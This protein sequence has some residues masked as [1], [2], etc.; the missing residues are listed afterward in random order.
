M[1]KIVCE[2]LLPRRSGALSKSKSE[3][4]YRRPKLSAFYWIL[5]LG[6]ITEVMDYWILSLFAY[7]MRNSWLP[8]TLRILWNWTIAIFHH[9]PASKF[10]P[11]MGCHYKVEAGVSGRTFECLGF[12]Q[13]VSRPIHYELEGVHIRTLTPAQNASEVGALD[14]D[15]GSGT[16]LS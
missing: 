4:T 1:C 10:G 9:P 7:L 15:P 2:Y 12:L 14:L 6:N 16:R 3:V 8:L 5:K 13:L 11:R